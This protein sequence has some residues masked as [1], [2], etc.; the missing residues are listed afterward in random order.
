M[1]YLV[2]EALAELVHSA[3]QLAALALPLLVVAH[4]LSCGPLPCSGSGVVVHVVVPAPLVYS[5]LPA[6]GSEKR[7]VGREGLRLSE[8]SLLSIKRGWLYQKE[9]TTV[10]TSIQL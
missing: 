1:E 10:S 5:L 2:E 8:T 4:R 9:S 6:E 3:L 7:G